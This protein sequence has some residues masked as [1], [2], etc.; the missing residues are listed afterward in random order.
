[1]GWIRILRFRRTLS[2][3]S[4]RTNSGLAPELVR[5]FA[6]PLESPPCAADPGHE[7]ETKHLSSPVGRIPSYSSIIDFVY[8]LKTRARTITE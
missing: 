3:G 4:R 6:G 7:G 2:A 1:M 8:N 5:H